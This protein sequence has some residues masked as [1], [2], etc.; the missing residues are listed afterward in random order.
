MRKNHSSF[1]VSLLR[2]RETNIWDKVVVYPSPVFSIEGQTREDKKLQLG[3]L[4][5]PVI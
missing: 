3:V 4:L 2:S 1:H 5:H